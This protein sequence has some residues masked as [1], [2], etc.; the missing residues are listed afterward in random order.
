MHTRY[1]SVRV[2]ERR[3][4]RARETDMPEI[5]SS[6]ILFLHR[7]LSETLLSCQLILAWCCYFSLTY[8]KKETSPAPPDASYEECGCCSSFLQ[9]TLSESI[10]TRPLLSVPSLHIETIFLLME[11]VLPSPDVQSRWKSCT[12]TFHWLD[13]VNSVTKT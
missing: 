1:T 12:H 3:G 6:S 13:C 4:R 11:N 9:Q 7:W 8:N 5:C 2:C 10:S